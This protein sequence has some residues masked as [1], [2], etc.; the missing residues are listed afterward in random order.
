MTDEKRFFRRSNFLLGFFA[1][2]LACFVFILYDAQIINGK[3]YL[4]RSTV[5]LPKT[6]TV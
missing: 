3:D 6:E 4:A 1:L 5:Q 2:C